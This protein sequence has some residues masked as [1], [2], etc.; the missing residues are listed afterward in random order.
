M[1]QGL[2]A[3]Y[4]GK[5]IRVSDKMFVG[6]DPWAKQVVV[7]HDVGDNLYCYH[8]PT[9]ELPGLA[10]ALWRQFGFKGIA[11]WLYLKIIGPARYN[12]K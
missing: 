10:W 11:E 2:K 4:P 9:W 5:K 8:V 6:R 12:V 7:I 1:L 3:Q